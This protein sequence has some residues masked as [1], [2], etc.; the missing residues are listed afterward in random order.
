MLANRHNHKRF[1][2]ALEHTYTD[3]GW[4]RTHN[5]EAVKDYLGRR[6][7]RDK[8]GRNYRPFNLLQQA[9]TTYL[10][11]LSAYK[12]IPKI[13]SRGSATRAEC[14]FREYLC[15][16]HLEAMQYPATD[17][18]VVLDSLLAPFGAMKLNIA[19]GASQFRDTDRATDMGEIGA[20]RIAPED[21]L[22][23]PNAT[24]IRSCAWMADRYVASK[25]KLVAVLE[26]VGMTDKAELVKKLTPR[27]H[28]DNATENRGLGET[29]DEETTI[30]DEIVLWDVVIFERN[31]VYVGTMASWEDTDVKEWI[32]EPEPYQGGERGPYVVLSLLDSPG[33]PVGM[34]LADQMYELQRTMNQIGEKLYRQIISTKR[35]NAFKPN[36]RRDA[37]TLRTAKDDDWVPVGDP[38]FF[39][40]AKQGGMLAEMAP[41]LEVLMMAANKATANVDVAGGRN[42]NSGTATGAAIQNERVS[43]AFS[44]MVERCNAMRRQ[45]IRRMNFWLDELPALEERRVMR[46]DFGAFDLVYSNATRRSRYT[47]FDYDCDVITADSL[48]PN[49]R[50]ARMEGAL[51]AIGRVIPMVQATGGSVEEAIDAIA[52]EFQWDGLRRIWPTRNAQ[53]LREQIDSMNKRSD[54]EGT[55]SGPKRMVDSVRSAYAPSVPA[56]V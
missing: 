52:A 31:E 26:S 33:Q 13:I 29:P 48:D 23:D 56:G 17:R 36:R 22:F 11:N 28:L 19:V 51:G 53:A 6:R 27:H 8:I 5:K 21:M 9:V 1:R 25:D 40:E 16:Q 7:S 41:G 35:V 2:D 38:D 46:S 4:L 30:D 20:N 43:V 39:K 45:V 49:M 24:S 44:D 34:S 10:P 50:L 14:E 54:P 55:Q 12:V 32:V 15:S 3:F 47:D 18:E 37:D 42:R